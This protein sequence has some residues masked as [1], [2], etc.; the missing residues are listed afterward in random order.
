M[1]RAEPVHSPRPGAAT[2]LARGAS[3]PRRQL[4]G[5]PA[6]HSLPARPLLRGRGRAE[7]AAP[8]QAPWPLASAPRRST[9][10]LPG[11]PRPPQSPGA[12]ASPSQDLQ[13]PP[14][15][16]SLTRPLPQPP[17]PPRAWA[18]Q[19]AGPAARARGMP[20][21]T[22]GGSPHRRPG[23]R[24]RRGRRRQTPSLRAAF[25]RGGRRGGGGGGH[26]GGCVGRRRAQS[27]GGAVGQSAC[28][29]GPLGGKGGVRPRPNVAGRKGRRRV[30]KKVPKAIQRCFAHHGT[31]TPGASWR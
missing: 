30:L 28:E 22:R 8:K 18:A 26:I 13:T 3:R 9:L 27:G 16:G 4:R 7:H 25:R 15:S 14:R 29:S 2:G 24:A 12:P 19:T 21:R 23:A 6:A 10:F 17:A 1:G 31:R 5:T 20:L 11:P